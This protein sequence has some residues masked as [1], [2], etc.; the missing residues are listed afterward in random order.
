MAFILKLSVHKYDSSSPISN[1]EKLV[2]LLCC[3][4][5]ILWVIISSTSTLALVGRM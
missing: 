4:V 5:I 3:L 2:A 1:V